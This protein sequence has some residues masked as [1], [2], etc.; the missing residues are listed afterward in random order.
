MAAMW[1]KSLTV[2]RV[3]MNFGVESLST[4]SEHNL[5]CGTVI[6]IRTEVKEHFV[7]DTDHIYIYTHIPTV[8]VKFIC[9]TCSA[10]SWATQ[11]ASV[12]FLI[13]AS[14]SRHLTKAPSHPPLP[15]PLPR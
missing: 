10:R 13:K 1:G 14:S 7:V 2:G 4:A 6:S 11:T 12:I 3:L 5:R 15:R 9:P 8:F